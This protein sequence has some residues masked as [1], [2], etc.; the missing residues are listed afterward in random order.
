MAFLAAPEEDLKVWEL[1]RGY[2]LLIAFFWVAIATE[3]E[4]DSASVWRL[5]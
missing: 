1:W 2:S 3:A 4:S 5:V